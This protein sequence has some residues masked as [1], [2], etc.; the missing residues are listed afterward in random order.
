MYTFAQLRTKK[1]IHFCVTTSKLAS[2]LTQNITPSM[3][4]FD[5][6][7]GGF[8]FLKGLFKE[9]KKGPLIQFHSNVSR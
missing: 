7:L 3:P 8:L 4:L 9:Y 6:H 2:F 1:L 5:A